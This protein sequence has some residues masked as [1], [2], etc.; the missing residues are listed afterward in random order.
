MQI[1]S[2]SSRG[3]SGTELLRCCTT[4][5]LLRPRGWYRYAAHAGWALGKN[6]GVVLSNFNLG[7]E[8]LDGANENDARCFWFGLVGLSK[9]KKV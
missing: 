5:S 7:A 2:K 6:H 4:I 9:K 1:L 3:L 8:I